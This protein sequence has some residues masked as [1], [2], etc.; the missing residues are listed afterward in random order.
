MR[1]GKKERQRGNVSRVDEL[2]DGLI[3]HRQI[4]LFLDTAAGNLCPALEDGLNARPLDGARM[5]GVGGDAERPSS[6]DKVLVNPTS[7]H[8]VAE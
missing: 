2:L 8:F 6:S 4:D 7:P 3:G 1:P 5:D